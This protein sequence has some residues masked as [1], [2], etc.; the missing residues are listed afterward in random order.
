MATIRQATPFPAAIVELFAESPLAP[1]MYTGGLENHPDLVARLAEVRPLAGTAAACLRQ[2]RNPVVLAESLRD[3]GWP[4]L[5]VLPGT[6]S[7]PT[8]DW[9]I[10]PV[11][12]AA[13]M[14]IRRRAAGECAV[15]GESFYYQRR[16]ALEARLVGATYVMANGRSTLLGVCR[17]YTTDEHEP[18]LPRYL[19]RGSTTALWAAADWHALARLGRLLAERFALR[20]VVGVDLAY[21]GAAWWVLEVNPRYPASAELLDVDRSTSI[22]ALHLLSCLTGELP[23][24]A[25]RQLPRSVAKWI[26]YARQPVVWTALLADWWDRRLARTANP[27]DFPL[28]ADIP[29][30]GTSFAA[31]QPICTMLV[32]MPEGAEEAEV[33]RAL[34]EH[35]F[36]TILACQP[37]GAARAQAWLAARPTNRREL[38]ELTRWQAC[39]PRTARTLQMVVDE[40]LQERLTGT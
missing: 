4:A 38:S 6:V 14:G 36:A 8:G 26:V 28:L 12:S 13:G 11:R 29:V 5:E 35:L 37:A 7:P 10:K 19:Y 20:G 31:G 23:V 17:Q 24:E 34:D 27:G 15:A 30:T 16:V 32:E 40:L 9:L 22:V 21:D 18:D 3:A 2:I 39:G 33:P 25:C 1:W